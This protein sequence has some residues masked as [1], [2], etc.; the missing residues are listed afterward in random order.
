M[1]SGAAPQRPRQVII[2][3]DFPKQ[4]THTVVWLSEMNLDIDLV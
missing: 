1:E 3:A 4:A 2:A